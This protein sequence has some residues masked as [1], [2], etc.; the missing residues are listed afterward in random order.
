MENIFKY[1][2]EDDFIDAF[3]KKTQRKVKHNIIEAGKKYIKLKGS[4]LVARLTTVRNKLYAHT[5]TK[6]NRNQFAD[7]GQAEELLRKTLPILN[8]LNLS[9]SDKVEPYDKISI[10]WEGYSTEFWNKFIH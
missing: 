5:A 3:E 1:L 10:F 2:N 6:F 8:M 9:I 7:Y 4:H